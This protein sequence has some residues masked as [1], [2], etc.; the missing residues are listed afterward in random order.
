MSLLCGG[1]NYA[2]A[3]LG[4]LGVLFLT[5]PLVKIR[6]KIYYILPLAIYGFAFYINLSA[7]GNKLRQANFQKSSPV[8]AILSSFS[9]LFSYTKMWI[10][11]QIVLFILMMIP[12]F[13]KLV[14]NTKLSFRMPLVFTFISVSSVAC[15]LTPGLYALGASNP[16]RTINIVKMW[17]ILVLFLNEIYWL[18]YIK[19]IF[20]NKIPTKG[21]DIR[22]WTIGILLLVCISF[23][24]NINRRFFDYSSYMVYISLRTG[25]AQQYH[26][27]YLHRVEQLTSDE[28]IV[29]LDPFIAKPYLLYF[30]DITSDIYDWRNVAVA[31]WYYKDQVRLK[32]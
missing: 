2:T 17:F 4:I 3:L 10:T 24:V 1:S 28:K 22:I 21:F 20:Y 12:F 16:A 6:K 23:N 11:V 30:S 7:P 32:E 9:E 8:G 31:R 19:E 29:E 27:E 5:I 25:E 18:G 13:W 15:M 26:N 14:I